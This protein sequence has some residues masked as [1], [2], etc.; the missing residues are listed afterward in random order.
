[1]RKTTINVN[2]NLE[3]MTNKQKA[4]YFGKDAWPLAEGRCCDECN[5]KVI[6]ARL[7]MQFEDDN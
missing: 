2:P 1:M 3:R 5:S 7:K 6:F 4:N